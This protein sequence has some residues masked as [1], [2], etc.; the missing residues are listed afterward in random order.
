MHELGLQS[1]VERISQAVREENYE[2]AN[3]L[4]WPALDQK[5][6]IGVLWFYAG[7]ITSL[8]GRQAP[9]LEFFKRSNDLEPHPANWA[10][11]GGV[12]RSMGRVNECRDV[13]LRGLDRIGEDAEILGNLCGA[14]VNEGD[15]YPGIAFGERAL[16]LR[17]DNLGA[18]F[19]L[20]L[21]YLEAGEWAKGF[22]AYALGAHRHRLE[23][24]YEPD[25]PMLTPELH[26]QLK[27]QGK[28]LIV[29]GEQGIGDELMFSTIFA[30]A[31]RD[32]EIIFDCHPRLES[33]HRYASWA[34]TPGYPIT[35]HATRK[36]AEKGGE[37]FGWSSEGVAAKMPIGNLGRIYRR[38]DE[39]FTWSGPI[40]KADPKE[41]RTNR[42]FLE[43]IAAGRK[44][45]GLSM[46]G[47]TMSTARLYRMLQPQVLDALFRDERYLFVAL[48]YEDVTK[49]GDYFAQS[50]GPGRFVWY[51][52]ICW[53]WDYGHVAALV[54]ATDAVV[55][56]CQSVA[57][58]SAGMG[59]PTYVMTPSKPAWRYGITG[60]TWKWYPTKQ[61][62]L[63][64][65]QGSDWGPPSS[66][67]REALQARFFHER[68]A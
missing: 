18:M 26:E 39:A 9:A 32:Y 40:Y 36:S 66:V 13:L 2:L 41:V 19:N 59:H 51:P 14:Y 38:S 24:H 64:R 47:G 1:V 49:L 28:K 8:E 7:I 22:D 11:I 48:D 4:L 25:P 67:L 29:Y 17:P 62:R 50:Y 68:A 12:L 58:L 63:L 61:A 44:I 55:T 34:H 3:G 10:N 56:V 30:D 35:F 45:I 21:L 31:R 54:G 60:D 57:H 37:G 53:A 46:R 5:P 16:A 23:K 52:S 6:D 65:Q 20:S 27:G 43:R 33:M 42:R 15:P